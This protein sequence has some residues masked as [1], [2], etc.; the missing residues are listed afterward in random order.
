MKRVIIIIITICAAFLSA[1][2]QNNNDNLLLSSK[3][4]LLFRYLDA[5]QSQ[6]CKPRYQ[7]FPTQNKW[8]FLKLDTMTGQ[9]WHVQYSVDDSPSMQYV[10][11]DNER[12]YSWDERICGRFTL[13]PTQNIYN[14]I[15]LDTID[16]RCWQVQ[17]NIEEKNRGV[18]RIR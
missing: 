7:L 5:Y 12:I 13:Y 15:L 17:W 10:L 1:N 8:T 6:L 9:I 14:F 4:T 16:G 3:D 2:A 18:W 11:D